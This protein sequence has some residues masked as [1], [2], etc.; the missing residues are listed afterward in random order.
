[1]FHFY[2]SLH[3]HN[4]HFAHIQIS[5]CKFNIFVFCFFVFLAKVSFLHWNPFLDYFS[6][7]LLVYMYLF[8]LYC[9]IWNLCVTYVHILTGSQF[10]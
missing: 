10:G 6:L 1:M 7:F 5:S 4:I 8:S 2:K 9:L 3:P